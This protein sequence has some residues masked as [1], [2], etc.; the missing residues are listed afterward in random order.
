MFFLFVAGLIFLQFTVFGDINIL[1]ALVILAGLKKGIRQ[2][3]TA[4]CIIGSLAGIFS[5]YSFVFNVAL[6]VI[7]GLTAGAARSRMFYKETFFSEFLFCF[8]GV[9]LFNGLVFILKGAPQPF[10]F[11]TAF[12]SAAVSPLVFRAV[13]I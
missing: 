7:L 11:Y 6:Y 10:I 8:A 1:A 12:F 4:G 9:I 5:S 3:L 13:E 2:G